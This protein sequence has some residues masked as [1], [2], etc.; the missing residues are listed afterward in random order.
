MDD[1]LGTDAEDRQCHQY[2]EHHHLASESHT[3]NVP[4]GL[5]QQVAYDGHILVCQHLC[6]A[7]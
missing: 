3:K 6:L 5:G 7:C 4:A 2:V 1:M